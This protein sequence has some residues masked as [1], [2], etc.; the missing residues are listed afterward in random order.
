[1]ALPLVAALAG[2]I[3]GYF[4]LVAPSSMS[5]AA[6]RPTWV[7]FKWPFAIDQSGTGRAFACTAVDCGG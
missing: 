6:A 7:E 1:L 2:A 3:G 5:D 4:A